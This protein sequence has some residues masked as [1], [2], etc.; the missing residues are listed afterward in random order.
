MCRLWR[1]SEATLHHPYT[2]LSEAPHLFPSD[3]ASAAAGGGAS[4][5]PPG[6]RC[7]IPSEVQRP[8][9]HGGGA[10]GVAGAFEVMPLDAIEL[11]VVLS[12]CVEHPIEVGGA[13]GIKPPP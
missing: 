4:L 2:L 1:D 11:P 9:H 7:G 6:I 12:S 5:A 10:Q 13:T 8:N 3:C